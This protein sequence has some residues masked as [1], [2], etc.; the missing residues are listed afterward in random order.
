MVHLF[1]KILKML[2]EKDEEFLQFLKKKKMIEEENINNVALMAKLIKIE[3][4]MREKFSQ[5]IYQELQNEAKAP[6][7]NDIDDMFLK[8]EQYSKNIQDNVISLQN[9]EP[10][11]G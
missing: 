4:T 5:E 7:S 2:E 10:K 6:K 1:L 8:F 11:R 9:N 3:Q